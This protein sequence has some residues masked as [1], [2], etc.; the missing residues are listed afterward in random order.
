MAS[1]HLELNEEHHQVLKAENEIHNQKFADFHKQVFQL[2]MHE[3]I[4][5][6]SDI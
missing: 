2:M 6:A 5:L 1:K 4:F 3:V